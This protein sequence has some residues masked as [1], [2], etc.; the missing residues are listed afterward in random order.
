MFGAVPAPHRVAGAVSTGL[1][2]IHR[3]ISRASAP[4]VVLVG[5]A[6]GSLVHGHPAGAEGLPM[7]DQSADDRH[8]TLG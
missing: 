8:T 1:P 5:K 4:I 3:A 7:V 2:A 6:R